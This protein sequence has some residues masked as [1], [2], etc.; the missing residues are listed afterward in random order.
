[1][2]KIL[3]AS[4]GSGK[5]YN[6]A[7]EYIRLLL[8]SERPDAYRHVL[9][10]TFTNKA[11]DEM[12][13]R[14]LQELYTLSVSPEGSRYFDS[15]VPSVVPSADELR[16]RASVQ[17]SGI[18][19]DYSAF[20]VSTIDRFFQQTLRAFSR[21]IGQFSPYQ[22]HLDREAL[23]SE[24]VERVLD[25][26][27]EDDKALIGWLTSSVKEE[28]A[29]R[30]KFKL[31]EGLLGIASGLNTLPDDA[32]PFSRERMERLR[33]VFKKTEQDFRQ[34]VRERAQK[35]LDAFDRAGVSPS[36]TY[37]SA[38]NVINSYCDLSN[39]KAAVS[40]PTAAFVAR[41]QN[42]DEW[43][44]KSKAH[45]RIGLQDMLER[46]LDE[47]LACFGTPFKVYNTAR[48]LSSQLYSLGLAEELRNAFSLI[49]R[50][51]NIIS[52]DDSSDILKGI[53]DGTDA[54]FIYEKL[55]VRY[56]DFLLDEFQD[57]SDVQWENFRPLLHNSIASGNDSL[58]VGDVK[59]SIYRWR[60]SDWRLLDSG[61]QEE[62]P[63]SEVR[64]LKNNWRTC[65][66]IVD[67]NNDFFKY[68]ASELGLSG[69][70][71]DVEQS[72]CFPCPAPG[73]VDVVYT[74]EQMDE[75]LSSIKAARERGARWE[76]IA[77]LV[78]DNEI[79]S[80]I[81]GQCILNQIP[82]VSDESLYV[83]SSVTIRRLISQ[84]SLLQTPP[85][86]KK[87]TAATF[88]AKS[89][90]MELPDAYHSLVDL[91]E[92]ILRELRQAFPDSFN[93]E[94]P[95][96]QAFMDR[97]QEWVQ[98]N[99]NS[100]GAFLK[101][102][103]KAKP[104]IASPRS[105]DS[106][107]IMTIHK[108][109]G[110]EFPF[111]IFPFAEKVRL[112]SSRKSWCAPHLEGT[113]LEG[114]AEGY[115]QID[116][117]SSVTSTLFD[118]EFT[119]ESQMQLVDAINL[120]YVA[121]T[122]AKYGLK[123]ISS[124]PTTD[125]APKNM[126]HVL[127]NYL[128]KE[129]YHSGE[130]FDFSTLKRDAPAEESLECDYPSFAADTGKRLRFSP[131]AA[132]YFGQDGSFGPEA[133]RRIRGNVLHGI[134]ANV[135]VPEDLEPAVD[136]ALQAGELP[137]GMREQAL[138]MLGSRIASAVERGWFSP[139]VQVRCERPV[140]SAD[141]QEFRPDRVVL[142]PGGRVD[143]IDYKFGA[144]EESYKYQI[145]R[146]VNLYKSMGFSPVYGYLWYLEDDE[147]SLPLQ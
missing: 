108:A 104:K 98:A 31:E 86:E 62:F 28:L 109:K 40:A 122:R 52:I 72:A 8:V 113:S 94:I 119:K 129:E 95:H 107:R 71:A 123:I 9:A 110:L 135:I 1:M 102:W 17:L 60:G 128:G 11:T 73:S 125:K 120:F 50:E 146:Y 96:I 124:L 91:A 34:M 138:E 78:R 63:G 147:I 64:A 22:V 19:H 45:L 5:T 43:F 92:S 27:S 126:A 132:D 81:A 32:P 41:A 26:L 14:I 80:E 39:P 99:G 89:M 76:D 58:V 88:L 87:P 13:R 3:K 54:P 69:I 93:A 44:P 29:Q 55:G 117:T 84:L 65:R 100:L 7:L 85:G 51:K 79:G 30:G 6:L 111:V 12:K 23:V 15:L 134:M 83:K 141:G 47:F 118:E 77:V 53:I 49:Q 42:P 145:F 33:G 142:H 2:I 116:I 133:S 25:D 20:A 16:R 18:L 57:T 10:V 21:E 105:G 38:F 127:Y 144:R 75:L 139:G 48:K 143:I 74:S 101:F 137:P 36:D 35:V 68:A 46:P 90:E 24:S 61:I 4:A 103:E 66:T 136:A 115:Y 70:Y 82:V 59:Q 37:R 106:V 140:I 67:F 97:L 130:P 114:E 56:E 112:F 121:L 131:E